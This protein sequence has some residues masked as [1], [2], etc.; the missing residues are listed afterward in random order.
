MGIIKV[1]TSFYSALYSRKRGVNRIYS[2]F[3]FVMRS[4]A[5]VCLNTLP[6]RSSILHRTFREDV[7]ISLTSFPARINNLWKVI[8]SLKLQE[9]KVGKI[10][11]WLSSEQ[12]KS[13]DDL[14][15]KL[16]E[17]QDE[18][19]EIRLVEG[20][21]RSHKKYYYSFLEYPDSTIITVDDDI[22]YHPKTVTH[23][24]ETSS[25]YKNCVIA[26]LTNRI[27]YIN[28]T[29]QPYIM[30]D[31]N[32]SRYSNS[33][34]VQ[35]GAGGVLY[36]PHCLDKDVLEISLF[37]KLAPKADDLW[38]NAM[39]RKANTKIVQSTSKILFMPVL[40]EPTAPSLNS[41]NVAGGGNDEQLINIRNY[42]LNN[43]GIDLFLDQNDENTLL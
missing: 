42:Y 43:F 14:P 19:F 4:I 1:L 33:N 12:I 15:E 18:L 36:P 23:L 8:Y 35:I 10:I 22:F 7:I 26:N 20:D 2:P 31:S 41:E 9:V 3:R 37:M 28:K 38:L 24:L 40:Q 34:L 5:D 11:L 39:A 21:L 6:M 29:I 32:N 13:K 17:L 27:L 30:W 25:K 16:K